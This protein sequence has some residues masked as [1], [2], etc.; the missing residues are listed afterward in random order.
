MDDVIQIDDQWYYAAGSQKTDSRNQVLKQG[1]TFAV[2]DL[3]GDISRT[4]LGEQG[5]YHLGTRHLSHW[6]L[7]I[8]DRRPM[9]LNSTMKEDNSVL[10]V[11]L[12]TPDIH[13]G[14]R[15]VLPK[16]QLHASRSIII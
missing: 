1:D 7:L 13:E 16:G 15:L 12:T 4:G 9:L 10:M 5:V 2:L 8:N 11:E 6:E 3:L 14:D